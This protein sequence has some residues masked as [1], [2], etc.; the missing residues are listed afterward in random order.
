MSMAMTEEE[1]KGEVRQ[2]I[3]KCPSRGRRH[4]TRSTT[5]KADTR[6]NNLTQQRSIQTDDETSPKQEKEC[7]RR[8][9][10]CSQR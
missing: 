6:A 8:V 1:K 4:Q 9:A 7:S 10:R 2:W 3:T 5:A